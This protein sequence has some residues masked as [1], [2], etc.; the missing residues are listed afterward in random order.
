MKRIRQLGIRRGNRFGKEGEV[1][2]K[3]VVD[4]VVV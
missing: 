2:A 4:K 1:Q 3:K